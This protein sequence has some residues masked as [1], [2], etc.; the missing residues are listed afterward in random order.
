MTFQT[1]R[2]WWGVSIL[3]VQWLCNVHKARHVLRK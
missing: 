1:N 2:V 3:A